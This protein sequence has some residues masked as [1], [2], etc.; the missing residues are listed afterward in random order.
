VAV[1]EIGGGGE[2]MR[3]AVGGGLTGRQASGG[4]GR[5]GRVDGGT[6]ELEG[7]EAR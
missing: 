4:W 6:V 2:A 3:P 5:R 7:V 1:E